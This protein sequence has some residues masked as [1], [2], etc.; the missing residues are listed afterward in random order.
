[1]STIVV[2]GGRDFNDRGLVYRALDI[3]RVELKVDRIAHGAC[4]VDSDDTWLTE[5]LRGADRLADAWACER[6]LVARWYPVHWKQC[7]GDKKL[8]SQAAKARVARMLAAEQPALVVAFPGGR[9]TE[10]TMRLA[11]VAGIRTRY[12]PAMKAPGETVET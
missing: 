11:Q 9:G 5:S 7:K 3:I 2:C 6:G 10:M 1:M 4:G 12:V 8:M